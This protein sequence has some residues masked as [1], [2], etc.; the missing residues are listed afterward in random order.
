MRYTVLATDYDGT[1]AHHGGVEAPTTAALEA[2]RAS[3]RRVLLVT[4]RELQDLI[5]VCPILDRFDLV[6]AENGA[7]LYRPADGWTHPLAEPWPPALVDRLRAAGVPLWLGVSVV[8]TFDPHGPAVQDAIRELG[9]EWHVTLN[10]GAV[11]ALPSG[12]NKAT[13]LREALRLLN[14][15]PERV[16]GVGDAENDHALLAACGLGVAVANAIDALKERADWVTEGS[17]GAGVAQLV[18]RLLADDMK[19]MGRA[20]G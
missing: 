16:I 9:L 15:P 1:I 8:A 4:G 12:V 3:G 20:P 18:A 2:A 14:E 6:V 11:M 13:G 5:A 19:G 7:L 10:K 17:R